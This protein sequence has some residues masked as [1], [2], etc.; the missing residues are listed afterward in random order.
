MELSFWQC[1]DCHVAWETN[2]SSSWSYDLKLKFLTLTLPSF[3]LLSQYELARVNV[4]RQKAKRGWRKYANRLWFVGS[5]LLKNLYF[6]WS[7]CMRLM[8]RKRC[9]QTFHQLKDKRQGRT[10]DNKNKDIHTNSHICKP[11]FKAT[12]LLH[13]ASLLLISDW[14]LNA[15]MTYYPPPFKFDAKLLYRI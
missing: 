5:K 2:I 9:S 13:P 11:N 1:G 6:S 4:K 3:S 14:F 10:T 12:C 7:L 15:S 8:I